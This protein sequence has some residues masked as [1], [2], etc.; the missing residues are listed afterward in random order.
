[1][2]DVAEIALHVSLHMTNRLILALI[3]DGSAQA[4]EVLNGEPV[5][6]PLTSPTSPNQP[7]HQS[8]GASRCLQRLRQIR[9]SLLVSHRAATIGCFVAWPVQY[10]HESRLLQTDYVNESSARE[11]LENLG[12]GGLLDIQI[13]FL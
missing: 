7:D 3:R 1:M 13:G 10:P 12:Q 8:Y 2:Y 11:G 9:R 5:A 4:T 6:G